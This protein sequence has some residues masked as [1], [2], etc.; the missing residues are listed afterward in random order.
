MIPAV[1]DTNENG[2]PDADELAAVEDLVAEAEA[3]YAAA[4]QAL[5]DA[6][7][8]D[9]V[10]QAE[11][12]DLTQAL[13]DAQQAKADAQAAVDA[14]VDDFPTEAGDFQ[15][16]VDALTDIVIPAVNDTNE[17]GTPDADELAAV[18]DL[19][20]EAEAAYAAAE[21]ALADVLADDAVTQAEVDD[22]TQALA[23]AQQA[24]AD[25]QAAVDAIVDDFPTEAGD[26]QDRV[27]ALTDIVI[28]AVND[29]NENGTPDA[30]ELAA[31]EDL[32][33]EAEAAY[34]AAE[35]A[36]ADALADDAVTQAEVDD[37]TQAL[38]DAQQA[39]ADA[40]AAV[41]AIVDD[42]PTEAGDFQDRVDALTDIVIPA[43]NDTNENGTPDADELAAVEDLVAEAEAAYAAAEQALAD[44]LADDAVTQ[45]EVDDL[46][47][48]LADAQQAKADAQAAVDA[49]VDDFP[50]EA[51]DFQDRVDAL[52][53]I[54]IPAVNDT[55]ENGTPDADELAAVEDLV[56]EAEA[57][58][59]AAEQALADALADDAVT[60]AEV[61][62]LTQALADAQQAKADA[63]AAVDAIVDDFPTEAGDF[64]DRVDALTDIVIPAV[65]DTNEN[66]TPDADELAAVEDLVAEAEAAYAAAEQALADALAD[67]AVTQA[68]VDDLT[69]ALAD[70]Q[71]A[72]ADAQAAVDAIVDDF[73]TEA[74]D[75]QDRV[76]A[77]T[78]I[79]IPAVNDTNENGTPDADELAAVEDLV[80]EAEAA[81]AA[82]EQALAD[83]LADDAVTQAEVDDLTQALADAQQA[84]ADAQAAV[85]AIVDDFPTEA[86]DFQDRVDAFD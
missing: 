23:D 73:P 5:A 60:Q 52:T 63:Q 64:Q 65:N 31:V 53:D 43:V 14:I 42:F 29:T 44:V 19:V 83:A 25:A 4:E 56:A 45:A 54:V 7:A 28:P 68:E 16:R 72:K 76:D 30:D 82:A 27:D 35:Q 1:N 40:Q 46:T 69:Q 36:L 62:D 67:D 37:L 49:I 80:A 22:L 18:E 34:A 3:A 51:G 26:F 78:D 12:D 21:Q 32:V 71:Q 24:K 33:A 55:N 2:T 41:D 75:F 50:T 66:G 57:A 48:A 15:D 20:A 85:D 11:V 70:A 10:T 13:A 8:D 58:Y 79:V 39:K 59:A 9:A 6:L 86:G 77:L 74:G 81:Y 61:D 47:Q 84:K 38:A 17:N